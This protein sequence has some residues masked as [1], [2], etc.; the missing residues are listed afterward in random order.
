MNDKG[1]VYGGSEYLSVLDGMTGKEID[2][3]DWPERNE[4]YGNVNRQNRNQIGMAYLDG[5]TPCILAARGT[6]KLM[7]VDA[8]QL[9]NGKLEKLWRWDGDEEDPVVRSQGAHN[10]VCGDVDGDGKDEILLGS[11]MLNSNGTLRW[12]SDI[13]HSDKTYM[14]NI[15]PN[16]EGM[17]VVLAIEPWINNGY[18]VSTVDASTGERIW[19]VGQKSCYVRDGMVADTDPNSPGL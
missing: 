10:M 11:C 3:V 1:R 6:Y 4:R 18:V 5:K 17:R 15:D 19:G 8:W 2:R 16:R 12:S 14:T 9:H 13:G 7:T